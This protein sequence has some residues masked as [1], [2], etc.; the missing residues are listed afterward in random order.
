MTSG[1][2]RTVRPADP[3]NAVCEEMGG[4]PPV[5]LKFMSLFLRGFIHVRVG[6]LG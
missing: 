4:P 3:K 5:Q 1:S 2:K 6:L